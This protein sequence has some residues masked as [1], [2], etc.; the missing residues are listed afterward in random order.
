MPHPSAV[1]IV[2]ISS[3]LSI[4]SKRAFSTLRILP[5]MRQNRLEAAVAPLLGR[6]AG[7]V[8]FDDVELALR[9]VALL[10]IGELARERAV[11]E[12]AL[13]PHQLAG[14][15]RRLAG[16]RRVD[17]LR[18]HAARRWP[19]SLRDS[20]PSRSLTTVSTMPLT[21]VFP[22]LVLVW[23]SNCGCGILTLMTRGQTLADVVTADA[24]VLQVLA[25]GCSWLA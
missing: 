22:S 24:G 25:R 21:S 23:P 17:R 2:R 20:R 13:A 6:A 18:D 4:L 7:G 11:V 8:A 5:L 15:A 12:R 9:R 14:L 10:T 3:L 1:I 19:G 16:A